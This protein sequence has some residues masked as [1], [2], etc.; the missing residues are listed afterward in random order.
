MTSFW[1]RLSNRRSKSR[2]YV[3]QANVP[4]PDGMLM[5]NLLLHLGVQNV[6]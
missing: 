3:E 6:F 5:C 1:S 4:L 2:R